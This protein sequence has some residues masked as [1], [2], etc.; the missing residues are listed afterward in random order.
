MT[1]QYGDGWFRAR[2]L[3]TQVWPRKK[4]EL[5]HKAH[6]LYV[7]VV[8]SNTVPECFIEVNSGYFGVGFLDDQLREYLSYGFS[9]AEPS[10]LFLSQ[11]THREFNVDSDT[12]LSGTTYRFRETGVVSILSEDL[13]KLSHSVNEMSFDVNGNWT[14]VPQFGHYNSLL[15][16]DRLNPLAEMLN[17]TAMLPRRDLRL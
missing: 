10:R 15:I 3:I 13:K 9:E 4:A 5:A 8:L 12:V 17:T 11:V 6:T 14:E 2:K 16:P 1:V 7:A